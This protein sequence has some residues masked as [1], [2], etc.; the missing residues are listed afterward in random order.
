M[1]SSDSQFT[2][3]GKNQHREVMQHRSIRSDGCAQANQLS[4][5][6]IMRQANYCP[7]LQ[8]ANPA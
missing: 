4:L 2:A 5:V 6:A 1:L 8:S 3:M 7:L